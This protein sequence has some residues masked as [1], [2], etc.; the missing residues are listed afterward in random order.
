MKLR[1][2]MPVELSW[3]KTVVGERR[4]ELNW[5][6]PWDSSVTNYTF[7][8]SFLLRG[9]IFFG[10]GVDIVPERDFEVRASTTG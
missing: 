9:N 6:S 1:G 5:I 10:V 4:D 7:A 3:D 8:T 2:S